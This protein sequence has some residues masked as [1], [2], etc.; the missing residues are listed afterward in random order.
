MLRANK[1][2]GQFSNV[3]N[4]G[5]VDVLSFSDSSVLGTAL[6]TITKTSLILS[7]FQPN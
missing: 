7:D 6:V 1:I 3:A 4:G 2:I 5:R